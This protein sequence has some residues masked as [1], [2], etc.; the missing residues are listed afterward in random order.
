MKKHLLT[1]GIFL[2]AACLRA[3]TVEVYAHLR[4]GPVKPMVPKVVKLQQQ[5]VPFP[6]A[7][8]YVHEAFAQLGYPKF[9]GLDSS[10]GPQCF[11]LS[12]KGRMLAVF[13]AF[14]YAPEAVPEPDTH[15]VKSGQWFMRL[16]REVQPLSQD[17]RDELLRFAARLTPMLNR[18]AEGE[19]A[20]RLYPPGI[21]GEIARAKQAFEGTASAQMTQLLDTLAVRLA[22]LQYVDLSLSLKE[23]ALLLTCKF[24]AREHSRLGL[25]FSQKKATEVPQAAFLSG[26]DYSVGII[27][28]NDISFNGELWDLLLESLRGIYSREQVA[29]IEQ[30]IG[31]LSQKA[32]AFGP[33]QA[34]IFSASDLQGTQRQSIQSF[35]GTLDEA[36]DCTRAAWELSQRFDTLKIAQSTLSLTRQNTGAQLVLTATSSQQT[37]TAESLKIFQ[38]LHAQNPQVDPK[39]VLEFETTTQTLISTS[40]IDATGDY[41]LEAPTPQLLQ[42]VKDALQKSTPKTPS[43]ADFTGTSLPEDTLAKGIVHLPQFAQEIDMAIG[44]GEPSPVGFALSALDAQNLPPATF[45][46]KNGDEAL[47]LQASLPVETLSRITQT[48]ML[49]LLMGGGQ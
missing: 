6:G 31:A 10:A 19:A 34:L 21:R 36:L 32:T 8:R 42:T 29:A 5:A 14:K 1:L 20:L 46:V 9:M 2:A 26:T 45:Q 39:D 38:T 23:T 17:E 30:G 24:Q 49:S 13:V 7:T 25:F 12:K 11:A 48:L 28:R 15:S 43:L 41:L 22:T 27:L 35:T 3:E 47:Y 33:A 16:L 44:G 18:P 37:P 40:Y 4:L